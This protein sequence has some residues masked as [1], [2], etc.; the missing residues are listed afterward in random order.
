M[1]IQAIS[2]TDFSFPGQTALYHGKVRDV[3]TIGRD[4][5]VIVATDRISAFDVVL[6]RAIPCKGQVLNQLAAHFLEKTGDIVPNWLQG[7]PDPNVSIGRKADPVKIEMVVRGCLVGHAWREYKAGARTLCGVPLPVGL[8]EYDSFPEPIITPT[9]K[10]DEGHDEDISAE[11]CIKQGLATA[12]EWQQLS[13]YSL[14]LFARGQEMARAR[15]LVLADTKYE[16]G[17]LD[18]QLIVIDEVHTPDSSRY[19]YAAGYDAYVGGQKD[20]TP[21]HLSKEFVREWL[22]DKGYS[23]QS[24]QTMPELTDDFLNMVSER[25]IELYQEMTGD[26]FAKADTADVIGRIETNIKNYLE[27]NAA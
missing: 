17:R 9:T 13:D 21:K 22:M 7:V 23:G 2:S 24:G 10:A 15:G 8:V 3:Y 12:E 25:Y 18:G 4:R 14:K 11:D 5:L 16:F 27:K 20:V 1:G 26:K 6:T 19:F